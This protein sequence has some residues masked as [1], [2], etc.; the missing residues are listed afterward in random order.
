MGPRK[1][2]PSDVTD[3]EWAFAAPYLCRLPADAGPRVRGRRDVF[4]ARRGS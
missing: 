2:Y 4:N 3:D 1:S